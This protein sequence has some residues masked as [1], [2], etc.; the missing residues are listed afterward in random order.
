MLRF[1]LFARGVIRANQQIANNRVLRIAQRSHGYHRREAAAIFADVA[2]LINILNAA[3]GFEHQRFKAGRNRCAQLNAQR[4]RARDHLGRVGNIR[5]RNFVHHIHCG[6]TQHT[7]CTDVKN[8]DDA[9]GI[10]GNAGKIRAVENCV[11]QR[12]GFDQCV[13]S[14]LARGVVSADQQIA[15]DRVLCIAQ[16]SHGYHRREAAAIFADVAQLINIFDA[17]RGFKH[18]RLETGCNRCA[19]LNAQ[20]LCARNYLG[21]VGNVRRGNFIHHI[22]CGVTQHALGTDVKNLND[23]VGIGGNAGKIGAVKNCTLQRTS[24]E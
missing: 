7:L 6:V 2:Q 13:L 22:D 4:L 15:N 9:I 17:A 20:R 10:G 8:L 14:L 16:R 11:L 21:R 18:Q 23:A 3:R 19:Q 1:N 5:R 24:F 12:T